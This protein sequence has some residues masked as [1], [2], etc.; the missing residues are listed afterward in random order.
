MYNNIDIKF[1]LFADVTSSAIVTNAAPVPKDH[2][3]SKFTTSN[4]T[5]TIVVNSGSV[6]S[7]DSK[8]TNHTA[9]NAAN[10]KKRKL[11]S[12]GKSASTDDGNK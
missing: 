10:V 12:S 7:A 6:F 8:S 4:F 1:L 9:S 5:E 3:S 11:E 2:F